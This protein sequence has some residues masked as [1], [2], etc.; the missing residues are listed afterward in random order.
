MS[1]HYPVKLNAIGADTYFTQKTFLA[2][3]SNF[4]GKAHDARRMFKMDDLL[5]MSGNKAVGPIEYTGML[6][7]S[8]INVLY[9]DLNFVIQYV[10]PQSLT[11]LTTIEKFL[12]VP[13]NKV[14]GGSIDLFHKNPAHQRKF[15]STD[16]NLPHRTIIQLGPEKL[17]LLV[18]AIYNDK[19]EYIGAMVTWEIVTKKLQV[20]QNLARINS[21]TENSPI[22]I[23]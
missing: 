11:T 13:A 22:N 5:K 15:L 19:K 17:D 6:E 10:N 2:L 7:N 23:M 9:C 18:S 14:L 16:K 20:E 4:N 3:D 12:P 1:V 21:M 8:P